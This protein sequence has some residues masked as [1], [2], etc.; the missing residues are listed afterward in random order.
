MDGKESLRFRRA[1]PGAKILALEPNPNNYIAM[2]ADE[3]LRLRSISILPIAAGNRTATAPFYMVRAVN[4]ESSDLLSRLTGTLI[5]R[6]TAVET[7]DTAEVQVKR[8]DDIL[9]NE[10]PRSKPIALWIDAEGTAFEV[11]DGATGFLND[12]VLIHVEVE[13]DPFFG[14]EQRL[15]ED[16]SNLLSGAGFVMY[17][18]DQRQDS[19]Q[20]NALFIREATLKSEFRRVLCRAWRA[21]LRLLVYRSSVRLLPGI[22]RRKLR[23]FTTET[24][25]S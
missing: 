4:D 15:L 10:S 8:L 18:T 16:V 6:T 3:T 13:T 24:R 2:L 21:R 1:V 7:I 25:L 5:P 14:P 22:V 17:A 12:T 9:G 20:F 19:M 11:L 23:L